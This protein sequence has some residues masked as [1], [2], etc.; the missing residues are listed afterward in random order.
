MRIRIC[1]GDPQKKSKHSYFDPKLKILIEFI[2]FHI[3]SFC[4]PSIAREYPKNYFFLSVIT[5]CFGMLVGVS[6]AMYT[7]QSVLLVA[8]LTA[9]IV[10]SLVLF[11]CQTTYDFTGM[12]PYLVHLLLRCSYTIT[13]VLAYCDRQPSGSLVV[14]ALAPR[15]YVVCGTG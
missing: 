11:A 7:T 4:D 1:R 9:G 13:E 14:L 2:P 12:G 10:I 6:C 5:A 8:A 3:H 15:A